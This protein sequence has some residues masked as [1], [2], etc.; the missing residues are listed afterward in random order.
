ML[1]VLQTRSSAP[2]HLGMAVM[3][4]LNGE[5][6][7]VGKK[8]PAKC[9]T[10]CLTE[11]VKTDAICVQVLSG[12]RM[13]LRSTTR[14]SGCPMAW[15]P[16][17]EL[18][19]SFCTWPSDQRRGDMRN[20]AFSSC[21][22]YVTLPSAERVSN[23]PHDRASSACKAAVHRAMSL[24]SLLR[25]TISGPLSFSCSDLSAPLMAGSQEP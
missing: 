1:K 7:L 24:H 20:P 9:S 25:A 16:S 2:I 4:V 19:N 5:S 17:L 15:A 14:S 21:W 8:I 13:A 10:H 12:W 6:C 3:T 11:L 22:Y 23:T 18:C